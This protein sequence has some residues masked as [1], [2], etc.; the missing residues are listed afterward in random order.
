MSSNVMDTP[1]ALAS[2]VAAETAMPP[3]PLLELRGVSKRFVKSLDIAAK[4][5]NVFGAKQRV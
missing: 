5:A 1:G 4:V 3:A 2:G